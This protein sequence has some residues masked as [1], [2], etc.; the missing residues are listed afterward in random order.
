M[1]AYFDTVNFA[2]GE[3]EGWVT[4]FFPERV[5]GTRPV[6]DLVDADSGEVIAE[7][8]KSHRVLLKT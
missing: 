4:K 3:K 7:A 8:G 5:R 2:Y 6:F 1:D